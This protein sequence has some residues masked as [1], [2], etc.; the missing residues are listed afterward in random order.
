MLSRAI[1][2][3]LFVVITSFVINVGAE[4]EKLEINAISTNA[5]GIRISFAPMIN[6]FNEYSRNNGLNVTLNLILFTKEN[7]TTEVK[8]YQ[9][10]LDSL[11]SKG[12]NKYDLIFYD[13]IYTSK[14]GP[15][16][17]DLNKL[18]IPKEH[19]DM[20]MDG[21]ASRTCVYNN[22][23]VGLPTTVDYTVFYYNKP[24]LEQ[25]GQEIPKTWDQVLEIGKYIKGEL[26][27]QGINDVMYYN[28]LFDDK[29]MGFCSIYEYIYSFRNNGTSQF[30]EMTSD[31]AVR[32]L[33]TLKE[34][35]NNLSS[36]TEFQLNEEYT[37]DKINHEEYLFGKYWYMDDSIQ[38]FKAMPG[39]SEGLSGSIVGGFN[40]GINKYSDFYKRDA[41]VEAF[42][43]I[44]SKDIQRK[45][46]ALQKY[47]S[48]IPSLY[49]EEEVC[50]KVNCNHYKSIQLVPRPYNKTNDYNS[51]TKKFRTYVYEYLFG[52]DDIKAINALKNIEDITKMYYFTI[53]TDDTYAGLILFII[54][55]VIIVII[56][57]SLVFLYNQKLEFYFKF[58]PKKCWILYIIG[59]V[60]MLCPFYLEIEK[61]SSTKCFLKIAFM[62]IGYTLNF[63]PLI[64]QMI[65]E[66]P[67]EEN[68][69]SIWMR[70]N[71]YLFIGIFLVLDLILILVMSFTPYTVMDM[72]YQGQKN[73][74]VCQQNYTLGKFMKYFIYIYV[75]I[76]VIVMLC[77][78]FLEWNLRP[79]YYDVRFLTVANYMT[80][81]IFFAYI[82]ISHIVKLN[83]YIANSLV[84]E[85]F[86]LIYVLVNYIFIYGYRSL[87]PTV[88]KKK[89]KD[90]ENNSSTDHNYNRQE[91]NK[92]Q[93]SSSTNK[94]KSTNLGS[95]GS[96]N[97]L[98]ATL[99]QQIMNM[100][101]KTNLGSDASIE[102]SVVYSTGN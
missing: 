77:F 28:G 42:K 64:S 1:L 59:L 87:G 14:F 37:R 81:V 33:E 25:Y 98:K 96:N 60:L 80:I 15:H 6:D 13:H 50:Q 82:L 52:N 4:D 84:I 21:I 74:Q 5:N 49:D 66:I 70:K 2:G 56:L 86:R 48:A 102:N 89:E 57:V 32:A 91:L 23:L 78:V 85:I 67:I 58:M 18:N 29:E 94:S 88:R 35:M 97:A 69:F 53:N 24:L 65:I 36:A 12:S 62:I 83:N 9:A 34:I 93:S 51:Y 16:L 22:R 92:Y 71:R 75:S 45:Y 72:K 7:S 10:Q 79:L 90:R 54:V 40:I 8:D 19:L 38:P 17:L 76:I 73:F 68:K 95:K 11:F 46:F 27:A 41:V 55:T 61:V 3:I 43:F 101:Y 31:E 63:I 30:P 99:S 20:Y 47:F 44:T 26:E 39:G 100:H